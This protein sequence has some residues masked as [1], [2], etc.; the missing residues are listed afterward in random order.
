MV[1]GGCQ[2]FWSSIPIEGI[3]GN[4]V[5]ALYTLV[6]PCRVL[7]ENLAWYL[8]RSV[9]TTPLKVYV[10]MAV[11]LLKKSKSIHLKEESRIWKGLLP[12]LFIH[13]LP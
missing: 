12:R 5:V 13:S 9:L 8:K 2:P 11:V 1:G 6:A 10:Y 4:R 3:L 7:S